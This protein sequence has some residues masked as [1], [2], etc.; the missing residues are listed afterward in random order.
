MFCL[1]MLIGS[2]SAVQAADQSPNIYLQVDGAGTALEIFAGTDMSTC[3]DRETGRDDSRAPGYLCFKRGNSGL[4]NLHLP[5]NGSCHDEEPGWNWH[6]TQ[7]LVGGQGSSTKPADWGG[8]SS[9][10]AADLGAN[11]D[12]GV[13][14]ITPDSGPIVHFRNDNVHEF[15]YWYNVKAACTR[16]EQTTGDPIYLDP[17]GRNGG[18][19]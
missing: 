1:A 7:V 18:T 14:D 6:I 11:P 8:L 4:V 3:A 10:A 9:G 13:V 2:V 15:V 16:G 12:T 17:R 19:Q 5:T